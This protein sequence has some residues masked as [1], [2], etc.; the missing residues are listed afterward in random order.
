MRSTLPAPTVVLVHGAV[1]DGSSRNSVI[2]R[3]NERV[4]HVTAVA[5]PLRGISIDSA[6]VAGV[7]E[8]TPGPVRAVGHSYG[9]VVIANAAAR[10]NNLVFEAVAATRAAEE[11][12]R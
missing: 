5:N 10:A 9:G 2:E 12:V 1:A 6:Y 4:V 7:F 8:Q 11:L 3:L